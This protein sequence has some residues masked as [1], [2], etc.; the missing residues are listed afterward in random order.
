MKILMIRCSR[1]FT[2]LDQEYT[3]KPEE[4]GEIWKVRTK[5]VNIS[6]RNVT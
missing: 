2:H 3:H 4:F 5:L 1:K 6:R